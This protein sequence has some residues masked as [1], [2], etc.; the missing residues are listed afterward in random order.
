MRPAPFRAA[1]VSVALAAA[2]LAGATTAQAVPP[3]EH[4]CTFEGLPLNEIL[5]IR[6]RIIGPPPC[7]EALAGERWVRVGPSWETA[8]GPG[9]AVYPDGY[10]PD[11]E[12]PSEDFAAKFRGAR[13]VVD[14]GTRQERT[15]V[16]GREVLRTGFVGPNGRPFS[17]PASPAFA[18]LSVGE[19][20]VITFLRLS[21][22]HCD[23]L[24]TD[25][26]Q[27]CLPEGEFA[28]TGD[29]PFEVFPRSG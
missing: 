23:G 13:Y 10:V 20:T 15:Y 25:P 24:D 9:D 27:N 2:T 21:E 14:R 7:R 1:L 28:W 29:T 6:E 8:T 26:E 22:E 3:P 12:A 5:D 16:F 17:L 4:D 19:H 11:E 18:P